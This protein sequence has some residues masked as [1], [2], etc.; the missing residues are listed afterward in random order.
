[1][2]TTGHGTAQAQTSAEHLVQIQDRTKYREWKAFHLVKQILVFLLLLHEF[3][4]P[5]PEHLPKD[6]PVSSTA[7]AIQLH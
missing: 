2:E 3:P 7:Y 6:D 5:R 1:M 4:G